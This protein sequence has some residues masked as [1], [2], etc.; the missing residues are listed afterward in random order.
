MA[1]TGKAFLIRD[2]SP[3][4]AQHF[5]DGFFDFVYLDARHDYVRSGSCGDRR[6][7]VSRRAMGR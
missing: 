6:V 2:L 7:F 4:V 1:P 5:P 3:D